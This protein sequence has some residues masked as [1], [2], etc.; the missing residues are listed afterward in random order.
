MDAHVQ[1][2]HKAPKELERAIGELLIGERLPFKL[3]ESKYF[4]DV[5][6]LAHRAPL[7]LPSRFT[8]SRSIDVRCEDLLTELK[9]VTFGNV[10]HLIFDIWTCKQ[11]G[12]GYAAILCSFITREFK[13]HVRPISFRPISHP[14]SQTN[15]TAPPEAGEVVDL[16]RHD[17]LSMANHVSTVLKDDLQLNLMESN[18]KF[19]GMS[20]DNA[21]A[22]VS[23]TRANLGM[24]SF[25]C[26]CHQLNLV[27][28]DLYSQNPELRVQSLITLQEKISKVVTF[29]NH[30]SVASTALEKLIRLDPAHQV[31]IRARI[32]WQDPERN[33]DIPASSLPVRLKKAVETRWASR[34]AEL[35]RFLVL[36]PAVR[37]VALAARCPHPLP[38]E[39]EEEFMRVAIEILKQLSVLIERW[40]TNWKPELGRVIP[41]LIRLQTVLEKSRSRTAASTGL[42]TVVAFDRELRDRVYKSVMQRFFNLTASSRKKTDHSP[43]FMFRSNS[44]PPSPFKGRSSPGFDGLPREAFDFYMAA[45]MLD[46][47]LQ[48]SPVGCS[49]RE[50]FSQEPWSK[51]LPNVGEGLNPIGTYSRNLL[52][53]LAAWELH[54]LSVYNT[55]FELDVDDAEDDRAEARERELRCFEQDDDLVMRKVFKSSTASSHRAAPSVRRINELAFNEVDKFLTLNWGIEPEDMQKKDADPLQWWAYATSNGRFQILGL[56]VRRILS[57]LPGSADAERMASCARFMITDLRASLSPAKVAKMILLSHSLKPQRY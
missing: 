47:R 39:E 24:V 27:F 9:R 33:P 19:L 45:T 5:L 56:V 53:T 4:L 52:V 37:A 28:V 7:T 54:H 44:V 11:T 50:L 14:R 29:F 55:P 2:S 6:R 12:Q 20:T 22:V 25:G 15:S 23:M 57:I 30:S 18:G 17:A 49:W 13:L 46:P 10:L 34:H 35:S 42:A 40:Q 48:L 31:E 3:V 32:L 43:I 41:D 36:L 38:T 21:S 26:N 1:T 16:S 8:F 51:M